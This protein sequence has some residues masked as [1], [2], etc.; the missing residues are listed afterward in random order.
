MP[1]SCLLRDG[2]AVDPLV[3]AFAALLPELTGAHHRAEDRRRTELIADL[4]REVIEDREAHVEADEIGELQG[5]HGMPVSELHAAIDVLG[6]RDAHL[7]HPHR[8]GAEDH[9]ETARR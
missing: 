7:E 3:E 8:L 4:L 2:L 9:A 5:T 1:A 6:A